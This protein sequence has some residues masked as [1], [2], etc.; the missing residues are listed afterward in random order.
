ME[1]YKAEC[2]ECGEKVLIGRRTS[3]SRKMRSRVTSEVISGEF[4]GSQGAFESD[5]D[6]E[7]PPVVTCQPCATRDPKVASIGI[8]RKRRGIREAVRAAPWNAA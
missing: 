5:P 6:A 3:G 1:V 7:L 8:A 2:G 4:A